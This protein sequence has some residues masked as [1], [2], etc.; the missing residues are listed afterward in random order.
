M[1]FLTL[2]LAQ[3]QTIASKLVS[4]Y[5]GVVDTRYPLCQFIM[6]VSYKLTIH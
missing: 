3:V 6:F 5:L 2:L 1:L 4:L